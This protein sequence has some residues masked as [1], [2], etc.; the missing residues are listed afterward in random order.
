M[1]NTILIN[2]INMVK[3]ITYI[4]ALFMLISCN[5]PTDREAVKNEIYKAEKDFEKMASDK[6]IA[7]AFYYFADDSAVIKRGN[8]NLIRGKENIK[9][10]YEKQQISNVTLKWT[11]D[12][13]GVSED[14]TL[15]YTFG[16]YKWIERDSTE[17]K[18][19]TGVF[20]TVWKKQKNGDWRYVWD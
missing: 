8:D 16:K 9:L 2:I 3:N 5:Q 1:I 6:G 19:I 15:G 10:F 4:I 17:T 7:E 20:H 11:P 14:G 18:E 12:F 13:I